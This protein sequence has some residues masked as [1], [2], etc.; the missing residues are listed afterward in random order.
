MTFK[1]RVNAILSWQKI[2][3]AEFERRAGLSNGYSRNLGGVPGADK[4]E[5][6]LKAFPEVSRDW[7][8]TGEGAMLKNSTDAEKIEAPAPEAPAPL[9]PS[10]II[11]ALYKSAADEK[12]RLLSLVEAQQETIA[13]QASTI[14]RQAEAIEKLAESQ[15]D[16]AVLAARVSSVVD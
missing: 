15:K 5:G 10:E 12:A 6:I 14:A 13:R 16:P 3:R 11:E 1:E 2:S 8:L 7:L 9:M 4:L